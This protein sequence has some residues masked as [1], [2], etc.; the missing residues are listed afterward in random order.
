MNQPLGVSV[1]DILKVAINPIQTGGEGGVGAHANF[2]D[3]TV[4]NR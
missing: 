4:P 2:E 3:L 1:R